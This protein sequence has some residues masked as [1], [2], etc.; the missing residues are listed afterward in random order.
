MKFQTIKLLQSNSS[1]Q[2]NTR[3]KINFMYYQTKNQFHVLSDK[4][5]FHVF[6]P[7]IS[8]KT[9]LSGKKKF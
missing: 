9:I 8:N 5:Q 3:L 7:N 6:A 1:K 2:K 4:N